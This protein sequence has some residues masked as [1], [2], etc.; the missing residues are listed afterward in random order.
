MT[1]DEK[2]KQYYSTGTKSTRTEGTVGVWSPTNEAV[3]IYSKTVQSLWWCLAKLEV[4]WYGRKINSVIFLLLKIIRIAVLKAITPLMPAAACEVGSKVRSC[5]LWC[6]TSE[7]QKH[8]IW[9]RVQH[10]PTIWYD[11][12][13]RLHTGIE[14]G[15]LLVLWPRAAFKRWVKCWR[16]QPRF[17]CINDLFLKVYKFRSLKS[18]NSWRQRS[19]SLKI[20]T[21]C[22]FANSDSSNEPR[23]A[24]LWKSFSASAN[25]H[26][27]RC[28]SVNSSLFALNHP[29]KIFNIEGFMSLG[30]PSEICQILGL[31]QH[32]LEPCRPQVL[33]LGSWHELFG[34]EVGFP[35]W[36]PKTRLRCQHLA[37]FVKTFSEIFNK[38]LVESQT[39][40]W[41]FHA[42]FD[43][44]GHPRDYLWLLGGL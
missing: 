32:A 33:N 15:L 41:I 21:P 36:W 42:E 1:S 3:W 6:P 9:L 44:C 39:I 31:A 5:E 35:K 7:L 2:Q 43:T 38:S 19:T 20:T 8:R 10:G 29:V 13:S 34:S 26:S 11:T 30:L 25:W 28:T 4:L 18:L 12:G 16:H 37:V 23:F 24:K 22:K 27:G 40:S 14:S 17:R